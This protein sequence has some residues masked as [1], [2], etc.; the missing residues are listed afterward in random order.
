M[1]P[2]PVPAPS[3]PGWYPDPWGMAQFRWWDGRAWTANIAHGHGN[4]QA[5]SP[6]VGG[7]RKPRLPAWLSPPVLSSAFLV[8]PLIVFAIVVD[9]AAFALSL[10][11]ILIVAPVLIWLDRVEPEPR[12][13]RLHAFLWGATISIL[14]AGTINSIVA[15]SVSEAAAAVVSAPLVEETMKG[16]AV[17]Y[18]VRRHE[19]DGVVDGLV[20][21]GWAG[22]GFAV[23]ENMEYFL[24]ASE[25]GV[26]AETFVARALLTPFAHPLFTAW[27]GLAVGLAVARGRPPFP[28]AIWGW[29]IA[30]GLHAAWNG[31]LVA[32]VELDDDRI[33]LVAA[34]VFFLIF[35]STVLMVVTVRRREQRRMIEAIPMLSM[36]Y[37][38]RPGEVQL[39]STW[40]EVLKA[41]RQLTREQRRQ[42]DEV[43]AALAR[44]AA[45]HARPG[46]IERVDEE[47][48]VSQLEEARGAFVLS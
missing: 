23:I 19:V 6:A 46:G 41:R 12:S 16:L 13:S 30:V 15:V 10:V 47:R 7:L 37:G 17:I 36:R 48:L 2:P 14:V 18:A 29:L 26:L 5:P 35:V 25:E 4:A 33:V 24:V 22:L 1:L 20:Y 43:H 3:P 39:Y 44:L 45:L 31:S 38:L 42:F 11:P 27:I 34:A 8:I 32:A 28:S 9:G 40:R 21:A